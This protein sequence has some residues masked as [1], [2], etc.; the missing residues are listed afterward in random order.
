MPLDD[1][2][3]ENASDKLLEDSLCIPQPRYGT[4]ELRQ[5][6]IILKRA[7]LF[8]RR[9][10]VCIFRNTDLEQGYIKVIRPKRL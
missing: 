4:S 6:Y 10:W 2:N 9:D 7:L 1:K 5:F 8:S 3:V